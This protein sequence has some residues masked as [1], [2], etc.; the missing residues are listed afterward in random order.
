MKFPR[1]WCAAKRGPPWE[2]KWIRRLWKGKGIPLPLHKPP[3]LQW[4]FLD[5]S[6]FNRASP[7]RERVGRLLPEQCAS[8]LLDPFPHTASLPCSSSLPTRFCLLL[9]PPAG[10]SGGQPSSNTCGKVPVFPRRLQQHAT[11]WHCQSMLYGFCA[12]FS[13]GMF[14]QDWAAHYKNQCI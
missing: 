4:V 3:A 11:L 10:L 7:R 8:L 2:G 1:P 5:S 6:N 9:P 14:C 13:T 12:S